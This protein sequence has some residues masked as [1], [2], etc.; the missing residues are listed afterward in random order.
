[1]TLNLIWALS[2]H[3]QSFQTFPIL[4]C[5]IASL[6]FPPP[7]AS[8][9]SLPS[10][11]QRK[12]GHWKSISTASHDIY[13]QSPLGSAPT[14]SAVLAVTMGGCLYPYL[15]PPGPVFSQLLKDIPPEILPSLSDVIRVLF[16]CLFYWST[17]SLP[18]AF[19]H[20]AVFILLKTKNQN[21]T[22]NK[23]E[24][25]SSLTSLLPALVAQFLCSKTL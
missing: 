5:L 21:K 3:R 24:N 11:L 2:A 22:Q 17:G 12:F 20:V 25:N 9:L 19:K 8:T 4:L 15:S 18:S 23:Q 1:M 7:Q 10:F 6:L 13:F 16:V 14:Y